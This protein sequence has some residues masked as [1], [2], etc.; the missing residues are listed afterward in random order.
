MALA[1]MSI[2]LFSAYAKVVI[3]EGFILLSLLAVP[4]TSAV[5]MA[6]MG[7]KITCFMMVDWL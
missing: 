2:I 7:S 5:N 4:V 1:D 6:L 3:R